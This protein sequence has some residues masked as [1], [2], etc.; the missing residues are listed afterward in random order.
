[1]R[2]TPLIPLVGAVVLT[3]TAC[4]S[5]SST[6]SATGSETTDSTETAE[7]AG[8][9]EA[10]EHDPD[11]TVRLQLNLEPTSL[12]VT[13]DSGAALRQVLIPNVYEGLVNRTQEGEFEP[14]LAEDWEVSDDGLIYTFTL[15]ENVLFHDGEQMTAQDVV[16]SLEQ[17]SAED[18]TNPHAARVSGITGVS[19]T[20]E[21]TVEIT[22]DERNINFLD[23]LTTNAGVILREGSEVDHS[24]ETNG[25]GP[26][27]VSQWNQGSTLSLQRFDDY[28]GEPARNGEVVFHYI[29]DATTAANALTTGEID[30]LTATT[31]ETRPLF[32]DDDS[33]TIT[34]GDSTSW[35]TLAFNTE[36][37]PFDDPDVRAAIRMAIDKEG[38]ISVLGGQSIRV[39]GMSV[40]SDPWYEDLTDVHDYDPEAARDLLAE[41]GAEDLS[42]TFRVANTYDAQIGEY[43]AAQLGE[44]GIDMS[45][46]T[47]EFSAWLEEVFQATDYEMTMVLHV[48]PWTINN[49]GNPGY[50]WNYDDAQA[51]ELVTQAREAD[52]L[53]ERD[54]RMADLVRYV[55]E[56]AVSDWLYSPLTVV[57]SDAEVTGYPVDRIG[58]RLPVRD[59]EVAAP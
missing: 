28:H 52:S 45:I 48:D 51:Q 49:Y 17:S 38:L 44:V 29:D 39:G 20:D 4:G 7:D 6:E 12:D 25:T 35:M 13:T 46:D 36:S 33:F 30:I 19:A 10:G 54:E 22:I 37:E 55:S 53:E 24:G 9:T 57:V 27:T 47:M 43:L 15:R 59:I 31:V 58:D 41:A 34:E 23:A 5:D 18:S 8:E 21:R 11:A 40:P 14:A 42:V 2:R 56:E 1:M 50:Y 26:Y 3:L 32:E 16:W